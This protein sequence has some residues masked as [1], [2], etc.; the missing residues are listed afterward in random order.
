[1]EEDYC[2][3]VYYAVEREQLENE[4]S[5]QSNGFQNGKFNRKQNNYKD[6]TSQHVKEK[7]KQSKLLRSEASWEREYNFI[8]D[9]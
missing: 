1:M 6:N 5:V 4:Q 7:M 9:Y 8:T 3:S 2:L